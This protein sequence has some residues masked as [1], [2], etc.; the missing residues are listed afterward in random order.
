MFGTIYRASHGH[1]RSLKE[2]K[3]LG[4]FQGRG[5]AQV[6]TQQKAASL[7]KLKFTFTKRNS[8]PQRILGDLILASVMKE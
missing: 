4:T 3:H 5:R 2:T 8:M 1:V 7:Q 6:T